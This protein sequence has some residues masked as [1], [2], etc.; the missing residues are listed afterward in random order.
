MG[1][2]TPSFR[3]QFKSLIEELKRSSGFL[4]TLLSLEHKKAFN[5]L[6]KDAWSAES[7]ALTTSRIPC[8]LDAL[9][10]MANVHN[11]KCIEELRKK[12]LE[13]ESFLKEQSEKKEIVVKG[14]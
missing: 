2:I 4:N 7:A 14:K 11:K 8:V 10:L 13:L 5:L 6:L 9:N 12:I 3:Q 1:R